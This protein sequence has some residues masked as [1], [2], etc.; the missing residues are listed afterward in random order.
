MTEL[1]KLILVDGTSFDLT[2]DGFFPSKG[3]CSIKIK[4]DLSLEDIHKTFSNKE[5]L[6]TI[7]VLEQG[8]TLNILTGF[9]NLGTSLAKEYDAVIIPA[10][11]RLV[12]QEV[13]DE[14]GEVKLKPDGNAVTETVIVQEPEVRGDVVSFTLRPIDLEKQVKQNTADIDFMAIMLMPD[15]DT[16]SVT[17]A[18]KES[19]AFTL[20]KKYYP[21][22]W[23][24]E[25]IDILLA[26]GKITEEEY[27]QIIGV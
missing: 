10:S 1:Q 16:M 22:Y 14:S 13:R 4:T 21:V 2:P 27:N 8:L 24:K 19:R 11:S 5:N 12:L 3:Q 15:A 18:P 26:A 25:R 7:K 6:E 9:T 23:S 20:A 17:D